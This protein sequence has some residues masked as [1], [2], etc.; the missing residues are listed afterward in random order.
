MAA[1]MRRALHPTLCATV[2]YQ[3]VLVHAG[4]FAN[5]AV[6]QSSILADRLGL[7]LWDYHVTESGFGAD[8][9]FSVITVTIRALKMHGGGRGSWPGGPLP[10]GCREEGLALVEQG[11]ANLLH[12]VTIVRRAGFR[13]WCASTASQGI[14]QPRWPSSGTTRRR[15]GLGSPW[16][17]TRAA[18][19]GDRV[20]PGGGAEDAGVRGRPSVRRLRDDDG[21]DPPLAFPR[22]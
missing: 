15:P 13:P 4:P 2:K 16:A 14:R 5:I 6:G 9:G 18:R 1:W 3:P 7:A 22:S 21:Q 12:H 19:G 20:E 11:I 10:A 8:I 17:N